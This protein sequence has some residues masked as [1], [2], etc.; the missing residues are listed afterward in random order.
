MK[1]M[2]EYSSVPVIF[3]TAKHDIESMVKGFNV[4]AVDYLTKPINVEEFNAR[5]NTHLRL[6]Q[7][8]QELKQY[9]AAKNRFIANISED[10]LAPIES[11]RSVLKMLNDSYE[12]LDKE[13]LHDYISL[14]YSAS[15]CLDAISQNLKQ[16]SALQNNE[17]P[18]DPKNI[19][20]YDI[21]NKVIESIQAVNKTKNI[22]INN[23][24]APGQMVYFD[25]KYLDIIASNILSNAVSFSHKG[26][27][28][29][30]YSE[31]TNIDGSLT[32]VIEDEGVGISP[33]DQEYLFQLGKQYRKKGTAGEIG[34]GMGL[35][36]CHDLL[37]KSNGRIWVES[38]LDS[39]TKIY[40]NLPLNK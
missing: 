22:S 16:W 7:K 32:I 26:G 40:F 1:K 33:E 12:T 38:K 5:V 13:L 8:E 29:N 19:D 37:L 20:T 24:I 25:E 36:L 21:F 10:L 23:N 39:G 17:F 18:A 35:V 14:A 4:G 6:R 27:K 28:V 2:P 15:D 34:T 3:L 9:D 11:L 30:I 31:D